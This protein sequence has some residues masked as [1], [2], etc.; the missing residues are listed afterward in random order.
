[1]LVVKTNH[2]LTEALEAAAQQMSAFDKLADAAPR[3]HEILADPD[4]CRLPDGV[5]AHFLLAFALSQAFK[6]DTADAV[7]T[8]VLRWRQFEATTLF[9][10]QVATNPKK[11]PVAAKNRAFTTLAGRLGRYF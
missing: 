9:A 7:M 3:L 2:L 11:L 4:R 5:G 1:M 10:E 8:Y 6:Q